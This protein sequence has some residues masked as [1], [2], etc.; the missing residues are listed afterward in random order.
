MATRLLDWT[1]S[2]LIAAWF[3][4]EV[5]TWE[6]EKQIEVGDGTVSVQKRKFYPLIYA[7][8]N[9]T[10]VSTDYDGGLPDVVMFHPP[11][12]SPRITA[13]RS[14]FTVHNH[15]EKPYAPQN[16][17][18]KLLKLRIIG[19]PFTFLHDLHAAGFN[20]ASLFP[21]VDGLAEHS[22][23]LYKWGALPPVQIK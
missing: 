23:W 9:I 14:V 22:Y 12:L 7:A 2:L 18:E 15:P 1:E 3:A 5:G 21:G 20:R 13:Q 19:N 6:V 4:V 16:P 11:H 10:S 17:D 8:K